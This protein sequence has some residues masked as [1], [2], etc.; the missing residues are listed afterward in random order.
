MNIDAAALAPLPPETMARDPID[1]R[2]AHQAGGTSALVSVSAPQ[3]CGSADPACGRKNGC[4]RLPPAFLGSGGH[5]ILVD[6]GRAQADPPALRPRGSAPRRSPRTAS[7]ERCWCR[8]GIAWTRRSDFLATAARTD[9]VAGVVGWVDLTDPAS[10]EQSQE[11]MDRPDGRY[12]VGIRHLVH[13]EPDADWLLRDDVRRGLAVL[14]KRGL[15]YDLLLRVRE[16]SCGAPHRR[17]LSNSA[18]RHR[19]HCKAEHRRELDVALGGADGRV[20]GASRPRLVQAFRH[21]GGGGLVLLDARA[22]GAVSSTASS[23]S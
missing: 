4:H 8:P 3:R 1:L 2:E 10:S 19:P 12:L 6:D 14:D 23:R 22:A 15:V 20:Q 7:M 16:N 11:L 21:G 18:I 9:F 13:D 5:R 17:R